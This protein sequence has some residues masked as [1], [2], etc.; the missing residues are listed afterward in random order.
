MLR[1]VKIVITWKEYK[2]TGLE[3]NRNDFCLTDD[4]I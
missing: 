3:T 2:V 4:D 1:F